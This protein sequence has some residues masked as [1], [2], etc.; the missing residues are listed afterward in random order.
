MLEKHSDSIK[1]VSKSDIIKMLELLI[2]N[3]FIMYG[4][5]VFQ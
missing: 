2:K 3:I 5:R 1:D 4:G